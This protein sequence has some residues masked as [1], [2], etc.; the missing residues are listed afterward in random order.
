MVDTTDTDPVLGALLREL[1]AQGQGAMSNGDRPNPEAYPIRGSIDVVAL[2]EAARNA[3][4]G[5]DL[6]DDEAKDPAELNAANDG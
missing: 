2:A 1:G 3:L 4:G 6:D 5:S